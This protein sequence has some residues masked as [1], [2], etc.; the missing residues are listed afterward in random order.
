VLAL[1]GIDLS[2]GESEFV[3][4]LGPSG[5]GK[6]TLL[7]IAAGLVPPTDGSVEVS[8]RPVTQPITDVGI[9]FQRDLLFD[10]RTVLGNIVLQADI[11]SLDRKQAREKALSL[12]EQVGLTGFER[13]YPWE[14]SGGMRQRVALCRALLYQAPL[15]LLDEPFGALD[16]LTRDQMNLDLQRLWG[17][18]RQTTILVTHSIS[19]AIFLSD[20]VVVMSPRPGRIIADVEIDLPRP[21]ALETRESSD[22]TAY[23]RHIR[24][25]LEGMGLLG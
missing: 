15:L 24:K 22:F 5:C 20:R 17:T 13:R 6:S 4:I 25:V 3:S 2:V 8:G 9:V 7:T 19:E 14:L 23:L 1:D 11:R 21:R 16:A 18:Q 10:W 12:I